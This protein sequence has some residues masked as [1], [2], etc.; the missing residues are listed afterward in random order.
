MTSIQKVV[1]LPELK[2]HYL[3]Q[4]ILGKLVNYVCECEMVG[5]NQIEDMEDYPFVTYNWITPEAPTTTDW[6][7]E[8]QQYTCTLQIDVHATSEIEALELSNKLF[9]ALH[10]DRYVRSFTQAQIV[11]Q[12]ITNTSN[13]T[14]LSGINYDN[15]FGFDCSFLVNGNLVFKQDDL[16]FDYSDTT[17]E[18]ID[19]SKNMKL[20]GGTVQN[21]EETNGKYNQSI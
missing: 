9:N 11:P 2:N 16:K 14:A 1:N 10:E 4:F 13:R 20:K 15:D 6:L 5:Q 18:T 8:H 3:I 7:G 12:R 17:I 21:K 19:I